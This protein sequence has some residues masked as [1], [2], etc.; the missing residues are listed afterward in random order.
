[1]RTGK[2]APPRGPGFDPDLPVQGFYR[3]K[4]R[5]GAHDSALAI[6]LGPPRDEDGAEMFERPFAWQATINGTPCDYHDFWPACARDP[7]TRDEHDRLVERNRT[8]EPESPFYD[9]K[10]PLNIGTA[11]TPF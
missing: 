8:M 2:R 9:P 5:K 7:I 3:V 11:P 4:L 1:M 10:K 6:W